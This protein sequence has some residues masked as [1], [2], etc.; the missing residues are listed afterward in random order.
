MID[1]SAQHYTNRLSL[2]ERGKQR[3][4]VQSQKILHFEIL[5][6]F[7]AAILA[8]A[9]WTGRTPALPAILVSVAAV[10]FLPRLLKLRYRDTYRLSRL[11]NYLETA[12]DRV[13][14]RQ[15]QSGLTGEEF[16]EP[17]HLF[18]RD[19]NILG[20]DSVFGLLATVRTH[21]AQRRLAYSLLNPPNGDATV[22]RQQVIRE[23]QPRTDLRER[24]AL[25]GTTTVQQIPAEMLD[26]WLQEPE[27]VSHRATL[28]V[29]AVTAAILIVLTTVGGL[30]LASWWNL[31]PNFAAVLAVQGA[32]ALRLRERL[33]SS[34]ERAGRLAAPVGL[35]Q[36]ALQLLAAEP[37]TDPTLSQL[38]QQ[39]A[40]GNSAKALSKLQTHLT[41]LDQ[42]TKEW[43]YLP[44]LLLCV[45]TRCSLAI[46]AWK[47]QH[48]H[49][50][51]NWLE[52][53]AEFEVLNALATYAYEHVGD[54]PDD[55][56]DGYVFPEILPRS[57][58]PKFFATGIAHP[59]LPSGCAT[60]EIELDAETSFYVISGSN[61]AGKSTLLRT[62]G[63]NALLA[64]LGSPVR[65]TAARI[66]PLTVTAS[67]ALTDSLADGKSKF[68][69]EVQRL[70]EI[71]ALAKSGQGVLFLIDEIF[72]GTNSHDRQQ[73]ADA[74]LSLLRSHHAI[75]MLSTHDLA[76][77]TLASRPDS[78]GRNMHMASSDPGNALAFDYRLKPGINTTSSAL[79]ILAMLGVETGDP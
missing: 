67:L 28:P 51:L 19:L 3:L 26:D 17:H 36:Q 48:G 64:L 31:A 60:N 72:S 29:L 1:T 77:T 57:M 25:L 42:R 7:A 11:A 33:R 5:A 70:S 45:G 46:E 10:V 58:P 35:L 69:S 73:A 22:A 47:R 37:L 71:I 40:R 15:T 75:G 9:A 30:H 59:L 39:A 54:S 8:W 76:L 61:M 13:S 18:D 65:A 74:V 4:N 50:L 43:F 2:V 6:V 21:V 16:R 63:V 68:L 44:C 23:L 34:L 24:I 41:L 62:V 14:G 56:P 12:L 49:Q 55:S 27:I 20:A 66:S 32:I 38:Q 53:W 52:A 79:A 78:H